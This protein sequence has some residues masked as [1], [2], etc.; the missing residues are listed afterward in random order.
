LKIYNS[1]NSLGHLDIVRPLLYNGSDIELRNNTGM[2]AIELAIKESKL[3]PTNGTKKK[4]ITLLKNVKTLTQ[5]L[6]NCHLEE[7]VTNFIA[8]NLVNP[9]DLCRKSE[10]KFEALGFE[11]KPE[12][13]S[14]LKK[15]IAILK[16]NLM[17]EKYKAGAL[18]Q[19]EALTS[20]TTS[21]LRAEITDWEIPGNELEYCQ[22]LG[23]GT[24]GTVFRGRYRKIDKDVA[25][26]V[27]YGSSKNHI[28]EFI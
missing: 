23:K 12:A 11:L 21:I 25:I 2:N 5:I 13:K 15:E 19:S 9:G 17:K 16:E 22:T 6:K 24:S 26:K 7:Y 20:S 14:L 4:I 8:N 27:L 10:E 3:D 28:E 1:K 18:R